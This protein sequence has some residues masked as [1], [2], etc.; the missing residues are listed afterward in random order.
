MDPYLVVW[1][2]RNSNKM[3]LL[4]EFIIPKFIE[5][6]TCFKRHT[7]HNQQLETVYAASGFSY[8]ALTTAG[9]HMGI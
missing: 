9:H 6:S 2:S 1:L 7:V 4:I 5:G 8:S 3:Q